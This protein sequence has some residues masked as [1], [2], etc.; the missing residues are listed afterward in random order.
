MLCQAGYS[1]TRACQWLELSRSSF[2]YSS[3]DK[4]DSQVEQAIREVHSYSVPQIIAIP[5][6]ASGRADVIALPAGLQFGGWLGLLVVGW[7]ALWLYRTGTRS[8]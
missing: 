2:Y 1:A 6:V 5:I 4:D 3:V 8:A 7:L